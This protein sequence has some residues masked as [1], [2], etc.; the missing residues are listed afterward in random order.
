[1]LAQLEGG[2]D[3]AE[4]TASQE[5]QPQQVQLSTTPGVVLCD[6]KSNDCSLMAVV[7]RALA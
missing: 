6:H 5:Q 1:M 3:T 4:S 7:Q 2:S